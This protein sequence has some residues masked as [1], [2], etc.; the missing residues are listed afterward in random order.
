MTFPASHALPSDPFALLDALSGYVER[1]RSGSDIPVNVQAD[2]QALTVTVPVPGAAPGDVGVTIEDGV[3]T[4]AVA[5]Q[6]AVP[7]R[8]WL[9]R[10]LPSGNRRV[11]VALP[12]SVDA[13]RITASTRDG[14]LTV[15]LPRSAATRPRTVP[16]SA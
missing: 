12:V 8:A 16:V 5:G 15:T 7:G 2:D 1:H 4:V 3:L 13:E 14:V 9:R 6:P 11:A 10:E